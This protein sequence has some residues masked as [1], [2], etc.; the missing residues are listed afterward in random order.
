MRRIW[1]RTAWLVAG[2]LVALL[3]AG[4]GKDSSA[5]AGSGSQTA[6]TAAPGG[7]TGGSAATAKRSLGTVRVGYLPASHDTLYFLAQELGFFKE[8]GLEVEEFAFKSSGEILEAMKA[9]RIDIGIPGIAAPV[10]FIAKGA[11]FKMVG[12]AAWYSAMVVTKPERVGEF[13]TM[14]DYRGKT[15]GTVRLS[16]GDITWRWGL[17]QAGL[18]PAR[19][20]T[21]REF[22]SPGDLLSA[23][24]AGQVDAAILWEPY[25]TIA[26]SQGLK[27]ISWTKQIYPHPCC[28]QVVRA[29]LTEKNPDAVVAYLKGIIRAA[30]FFNDEANKTRVLEVLRK[31]LKVDDELIRKTI[32]EPDPATG[33]HR[34]TV[35]PQL[36]TE[37]VKK[38]V[39]MMRE[40]GY[41]DEAG[42]SRAVQAV[43]ERFIVRAYKELGL[44]KTDEEARRLAA[45]GLVHTAH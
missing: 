2:L 16:T 28:R 6:S 13:R 33:E 22:G 44:A 10:A 23:A 15:V 37:D 20:V 25:G 30:A 29:E 41:I 1:S 5:P 45:Q 42:A 35:S 38:Y 31:Y 7:A 19:D 40:I 24:K 36:G 9:G 12:G 26:E 34:T 18:D 11:D 17:K 43:D 3:A 8:E 32:L 14:E 4:C 21:I 27:I 39:E